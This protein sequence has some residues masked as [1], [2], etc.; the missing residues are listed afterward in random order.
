MHHR[1]MWPLP[2]VWL[3]TSVEDQQRAD[4]R[5]PILL[6]TPA[7]VRWL[8]CE[9][10]LGP[11]DMHPKWARSLRD[12][13]E[14]ACVPFLFKQWGEWTPMPAVADHPIW[15]QPL[16]ADRITLEAGAPLYRVGKKVAGRLLDGVQHDGYPA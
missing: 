16:P 15:G 3:G 13:C 12:Q 6:D 9:P 14:W 1:T 2:N 11:V 4:E 8:S 7:A 10:L 5:I